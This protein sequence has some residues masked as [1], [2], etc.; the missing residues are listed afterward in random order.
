MKEGQNKCIF[1]PQRRLKFGL[2]FST[3]NF[4]LF[5]QDPEPGDEDDAEDKKKT[6]NDTQANNKRKDTKK[7]EL[8][9]EE[10]RSNTHTI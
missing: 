6:S 1:G 10:Q 7:E 3:G 8:H 9:W 4:A 2:F 5:S